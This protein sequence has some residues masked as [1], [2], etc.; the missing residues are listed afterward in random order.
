M[1]KADIDQDIVARYI[2]SKATEEERTKL[3]KQFEGEAR[4]MP[5]D[6]VADFKDFVGIEQKALYE[7]RQARQNLEDV[8]LIPKLVTSVKALEEELRQMKLDKLIA[9][10]IEDEDI[11]PDITNIVQEQKVGIE[12]ITG[13]GYNLGPRPFT[14]SQF[15]IFGRYMGPFYATPVLKD[16]DGQSQESG[17]HSDT[18]RVYRGTVTAGNSN[19]FWPRNKDPDDDDFAYAD[20]KF[21]HSILGFGSAIEATGDWLVY[22]EVAV[23]PRAER[24]DVLWDQG[25]STYY[26]D[27]AQRYVPIL[28]AYHVRGGNAWINQNYSFADHTQ[29]DDWAFCGEGNANPTRTNPRAMGPSS[30]YFPIAKFVLGR[31]ALT[32]DDAQTHVEIAKWEPKWDASDIYCPVWQWMHCSHEDG[33]VDMPD[34]HT[35]ECVYAASLCSPTCFTPWGIFTDHTHFPKE[36]DFMAWKNSSFFGTGYPH[37]PDCDINGTG[38]GD[39]QEGG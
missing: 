30:A 39:H 17:K 2:A 26:D 16:G 18:L 6:T 29:A 28:R 38:I 32:T 15:E 20:F 7:E 37:D 31:L 4:D 5:T 23:Y 9:E 21:N 27:F 10:A 12:S 24:C 13:T 14:G 3:E 22:M 8:S 33:I 1:A 35:A 11:T 19:F 34:C 25:A 36:G